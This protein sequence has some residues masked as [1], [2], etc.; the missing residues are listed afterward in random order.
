VPLTSDYLNWLLFEVAEGVGSEQASV[1]GVRLEHGAEGLLVVIQ[2]AGR[3]LSYPVDDPVYHYE[4]DGLD[5]SR[6][7]TWLVQ[8]FDEEAR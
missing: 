7:A 8:L 2:A 1:D 3:R 6:H 5:V 4:P